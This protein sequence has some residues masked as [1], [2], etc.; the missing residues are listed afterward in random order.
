MLMQGATSSSK[1][2]KRAIFA[3]FFFCF[4]I[5][6]FFLLTTKVVQ[7]LYVDDLKQE[8]VRVILPLRDGEEF[9]IKYIHSVDLLPVYEIYYARDQQIYLKETH[10]Y[11]FG[12]GMG[13]LEGRGSYMEENDLLKIVGIDEKIGYF[14]L[15]TGRIADQRLIHR[16]N[17]Y[18]LTDYFD[19]D[20]RLLFEIKKVS[21]LD[22]L[23]YY[24]GRGQIEPLNNYNLNSTSKN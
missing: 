6:C 4:S 9:T 7:F 5:I 8:A 2:R 24:L 16:E 20:A 17:V 11:N 22:A 3:L 12:A 13:L 15:R 1:K 14:V 19:Q 18:A 21:G 23:R 10:F